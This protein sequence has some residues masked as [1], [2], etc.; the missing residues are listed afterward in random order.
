MTNKIKPLQECNPRHGWMGCWPG[1]TALYDPENGRIKK[2][3]IEEELRLRQNSKILDA[4][5]GSKP[6]ASIFKNHKYESCDIPGGFYHQKHN[7]ECLLDN[8][9]KP[10]GHYDAIL[11]TQ[12]LEHVPNPEKVL[13]EIHRT[14][15]PGGQL[16]MS[17]PLNGPLH[18]EPWHFFQFS[19]YGLL[20]LA[21]RTN[22][23][24]TNLEKIGGAFWFF[25][26]HLQDT[27]K[28][29][30]KSFDPGRARKRGQ[31]IWRCLLLSSLF[32]PFWLASLI[33]LSGVFRPI[34]YW[35]DLLD[36]PKTLTLGYTAVLKKTK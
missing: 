15:K 16:L 2:F 20:E 18:G 34:C 13:L 29:I 19:H 12:V 31:S 14:L 8:I 28:R 6:Y 27:P 5:A 1:F 10:D 22:F 24:L 21:R 4:S 11:L 30:M 23:E 35:L 7:F 32:L 36:V 25:G 26:K 17:V 33:I 3:L 9:P